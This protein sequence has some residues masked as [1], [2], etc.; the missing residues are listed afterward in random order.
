MTSE[1]LRVVA[2][3]GPAAHLA[4][5]LHRR[6]RAALVRAQKATPGDRTDFIRHELA[7]AQLEALAVAAHNNGEPT[8]WAPP[9]T[10]QTWSALLEDDTL[11]PEAVLRQVHDLR[12][13]GHVILAV[14]YPF[15]TG[16]TPTPLI[17]GGGPLSPARRFT[18]GKGLGPVEAVRARFRHQVATV[19][20]SGHAD[21][22][23][24]II[25]SGVSNSVL[26]ETFREF[27]ATSSDREPLWAPIAYRDGSTAKAFALGA[28][29]MPAD[30][31]PA[32]VDDTTWMIT[33][34]TLRMTLLS[35]R[36]VE[37]D[38]IV[39]GAWLRNTL[40]SRPRPQAQTDDLV[41]QTT[42]EQ[43]ERLTTRAPVNLMIFQTGLEPAVTGF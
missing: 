11:I 30:S 12:S 19:A 37:L 13:A 35:I 27:A 26:T 9:L 29:P 16:P 34:R 25:P 31:V 21:P 1:A 42:R 33:E 2:V 36:H 10:G 39:D 8:V 24:P 38:S 15:I 14:A 4:A 23:E 40:V 18:E 17:E 6:S 32:T 5:D 7:Q 43:L 28:L 22:I 20:R 41:Y 3:S